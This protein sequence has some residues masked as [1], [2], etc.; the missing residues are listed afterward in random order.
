[1]VINAL[2]LASGACDPELRGSNISITSLDGGQ[3][4]LTVTYT[5][6]TGT[7]DFLGD[8]INLGSGTGP[9]LT[10]GRRA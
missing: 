1:M 6:G 3:Q 8:I 7:V 2:T 4:N 9:A 10:V 5:S